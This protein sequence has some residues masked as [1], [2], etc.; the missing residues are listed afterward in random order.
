MQTT[1]GRGIWLEKYYEA[2]KINKCKINYWVSS[3]Q[4][5]YYY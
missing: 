5:T 3:C 1:F 4:F 2:E